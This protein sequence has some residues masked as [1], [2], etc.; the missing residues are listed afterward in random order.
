MRILRATDHRQMPWKNGKGVTTEIAIFPGD[1]SVD[2]FDWRISMAK[3]PASGPFSAFAGVDRVLAV[4]EGEMVLT[5]EGKPPATMDASSAAMAFPGDAATSAVVLHEVMDLNVMVRRGKFSAQSTRLVNAEIFGKADETFVLLRSDAELV[6][7]ETL[8][9][10]DVLHI[11]KS[12]TV[13]FTRIP[14]D[15]WLVEITSLA[16]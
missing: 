14:S 6:S 11:Q 15:A 10:G 7:G 4:L 8:G 2:N 9:L 16:E 12:E 13:A 1:A 3:V 5:V